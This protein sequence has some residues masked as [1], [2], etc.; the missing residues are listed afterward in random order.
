[1]IPLNNDIP[2][3]TLSVEI[4]ADLIPAKQNYSKVYNVNG[5]AAFENVKCSPAP[6]N[7]KQTDGIY[8]I[9]CFCVKDNEVTIQFVNTNE[10]DASIKAGTYEIHIGAL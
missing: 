4:S 6:S 7:D 10:V 9:N 8:V 2:V 3:K 1:M 5:A